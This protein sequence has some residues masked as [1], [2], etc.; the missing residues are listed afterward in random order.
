MDVIIHKRIES[1]DRLVPQWEDLPD[2]FRE[3]TIFQDVEWMSDWW[4]QKEK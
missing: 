3:A 2:R 1:L 4:E